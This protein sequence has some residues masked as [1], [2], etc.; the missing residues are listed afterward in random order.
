[1]AR[2]V[3]RV[4]LLLLLT[5]G[6]ARGQTPAAVQGPRERA[7]LDAVHLSNLVKVKELLAQGASPEAKDPDNDRT[8]LFYAAEKGNVAIVQL[9]LDHGASVNVV[10]KVHRERPVGAA[11]RAGHPE[12]VRLLLAKD[13]SQAATVALNGVYQ[14]NPDVLAAG[15]ATGRLLAEDLSLALELAERQGSAEVVTYLRKAGVPD[16]PTVVAVPAA[17]LARYV[18]RYRSEEAASTVTVSLK[19]GALYGSFGGSWGSNPPNRLAALDPTY[20]TAAEGPVTFRLRFE[21]E[22]D[23][24]VGVAW[25]WFNEKAGHFKRVDVAESQ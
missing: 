14:N 15:M 10:E 1:M 13:D 3:G 8:V 5:V 25:R 11:S 24:V 12:V 19:D 4:A 20:F 21:V 17:T 23:R 16:P 6:E 18:G 7:L 22:G 9:L 2:M